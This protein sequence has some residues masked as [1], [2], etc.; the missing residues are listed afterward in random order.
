MSSSQRRP[1]GALASGL[2]D[3]GEQLLLDLHIAEEWLE[4]LEGRPLAIGLAELD[5]AAAVTPGVGAGRGSP[6]SGSSSRPSAWMAC[7]NPASRASLR[8]PARAVATLR[9]RLRSSGLAKPCQMS[10]WVWGGALTTCGTG[11]GFVSQPATARAP[12]RTRDRKGLNR[13]SIFGSPPFASESGKGTTPLSTNEI[14]TVSI[15]WAKTAVTRTSGERHSPGPRSRSA[16]RP[17]RFPL[18]PRRLRAVGR[19]ADLL[20]MAAGGP[21]DR[22]RRPPGRLV[23]RRS[24]HFRDAGA[25]LGPTCARP[26]P[27]ARPWRC[28]SSRPC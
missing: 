28:C 10:P 14:F 15:D 1:A 5:Q 23:A 20:Q 11:F 13:D 16:N 24:R 25:G 17:R 26:S 6:A 7:R 22:H 8:P 21:V 9:M 3:D 4:L 18:W 19:H 2:L 12:S 27:T